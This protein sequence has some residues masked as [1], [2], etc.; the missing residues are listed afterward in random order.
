M[1]KLYTLVG[2]DDCIVGIAQKVGRSD[3]V[4]YS[5]TKI[6]EK[7]CKY[8][9]YDEAVEHFDYNIL[10]SFIGNE[11]PVFITEMDREDIDTFYGSEDV[12]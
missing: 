8:M 7:L 9:E 5:R 1:D 4:A 10:G 11:M 3:S 2:F 12:D 6:I